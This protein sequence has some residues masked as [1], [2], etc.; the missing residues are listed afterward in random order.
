MQLSPMDMVADVDVLGLVGTP[1]ETFTAGGADVTVGPSGSVVIS[2]AVDDLAASGVWSSEKFRLIGPVP[3]ALAERFLRWARAWPSLEQS[4]ELGPIHLFVRLEEGFLYLGTVRH[5]QSGWR[6]GEQTMDD[7]DLRIE[8]P[9]SLDVLDRVRPPSTPATL[10]ALDWLDHVDNDRATALRLLIEGWYPLS[11]ADAAPAT[12]SVRA[13]EALAA[14]YRLAQG[15]PQ[16]LGVQNF[17]RP[18]EELSTDAHGLLEFGYENQGCFHWSLD[19][20]QDDPTVWTIEEPEYRY[21]ERE[22]LSGFLLQFSLY[23]AMVNAPYHAGGG[24][25]PTP[26]AS[27]LVS[28]LRRVPLKTWMWPLYQTSFYVAPG[29]IACVDGDDEKEECHVSFGAAHRSLLRPLA[30]Q[31]IKWAVF[32][33]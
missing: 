17:I 5:G 22:R 14:F 20:S 32:D 19:L 24:P 11:H 31:G 1:S 10:P 6:T 15:R 4:A 28:T 29:L 23:E 21:A 18:A 7:C 2:D 8:P 9:L 25:V 13:P 30:N 26:I 27:E 33:G 3:E 12:P 16:V